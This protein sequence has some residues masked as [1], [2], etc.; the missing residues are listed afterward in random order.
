[1]PFRYSLEAVLKLR[2]S[3]ERLERNR[4]LLISAALNRVRESL[5]S[6]ARDFSASQAAVLQKLERG[7]SGGELELDILLQQAMRDRRAVL[8][9]RE[10]ELMAQQTMQHRVYQSAKM[11]RELL[12]ELRERR[13]A[14]YQ[15]EQGRREQQRLDE[16]FLIRR[17]AGCGEP[18]E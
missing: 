7:V 8:T 5:E 18:S 2:A 13:L 16:L 17:E 10:T 12:D 11:R 9:R 3:F 6:L 1:M 4:L 14:Q 15:A